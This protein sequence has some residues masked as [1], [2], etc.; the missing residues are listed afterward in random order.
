MPK[1]MQNQMV[2]SGLEPKSLSDSRLRAFGQADS[3]HIIFVKE[4][5]QSTTGNFC[6]LIPKYV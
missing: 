6:M 4:L 2:E 1:V 3:L 5:I